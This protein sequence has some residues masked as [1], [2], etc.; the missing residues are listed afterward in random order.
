MKKQIVYLA[1]FMGAGKSTIGPILANTLGWDFYD[2]D[3][4]IENE[5]GKKVKD[6]FGEFGE[7]YFRKIETETLI[8]ISGGNKLIIALGGGTMTRHENIE[9]LRKYGITV[10]LII[11]PESAYARLK[12]KR[13]RPVLTGDG[14]S[15]I[16]KEKMMEKI[17]D[18]LITRKKFYEKAEIQIDT[19]NIPVGITVDKLAKIIL[20]KFHNFDKI[21]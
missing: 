2:L 16:S 10:H 15:D 20:Q 6:I 3:R 18:L 11:S 5:S 21:K 7:E 17:N 1:G 4:V 8:N 19:E 13:D 12:F 9:I 14:K